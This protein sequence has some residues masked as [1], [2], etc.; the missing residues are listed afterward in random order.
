MIIKTIYKNKN[1]EWVDIQGLK[2]E[3]LEEISKKYNINILHLKDCI[4]ANHLPK[5]EDLGD[6]QF[7]LA[8][9]SFDPKRG[10]LNSINDIS[11]KIG[12]F[13][14]D[15]FIL[16][17]HRVDYDRIEKIA[18]ELENNAISPSTPY[19]V[20]LE[21]G[22]GILKTFRKENVIL[23]EK[24]EKLESDMFGKDNINSMEIKRLYRFKRR[25][26]LN[27]KLLT[28]SN[29]WVNFYDKLPI[30][31]IE[32][33]DLKDTQMEV[34]SGF[35]YLNSQSTSLISLFLALSDQKNNESMKMLAVY[36]AYFMPITFLASVYGMNFENMIGLHHPDGFYILMGIMGLIVIGTFI[37]IKRKNI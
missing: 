26:G 10:T 21:L 28:L 8:R 24:M 37:F 9:L 18:N 25:V 7:I 33:N 5:A 1:F 2:Y 16:T 6:T 27:L 35:E 11:T 29:E 15:N 4:D 13:V 19:K 12:I 34:L 17:I 14:R 22:L 31:K 3:Y 20:A 32:F 23:L 36:S 30:E